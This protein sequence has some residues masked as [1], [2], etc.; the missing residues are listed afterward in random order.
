MTV[1][2]LRNDVGQVSA[3]L[4]DTSLEV[5][6]MADSLSRVPVRFDD[7]HTAVTFLPDMAENVENLLRL[8]V[9]DMLMNNRGNSLLTV[10]GSDNKPPLR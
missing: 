7:I 4:E 2:A 10:C 3:I 9:V 8:S 5:K 1:D 6:T